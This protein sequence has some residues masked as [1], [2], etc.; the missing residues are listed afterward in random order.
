MGIEKTTVE[1]FVALSQHHPV[2]DVR[3][4]SEYN[5]AHIPGAIN[6]PLFNDDERHIVGTIYKKESREAAIK[7][8][9]VYFGPKMHEMISFVEEIKRKNNSTDKTILV[10]CWRGGMRSG[11]VAWLLD[12]YGFKVYT[13]IG[14]YKSFR[15]WVLDLFKIDWG[16]NILGGYTGSGKTIILESLIEKGEAV[17]DLEGIAGH[18]GS[19]FGRIGLPPQDSVEMFENKLA[20]ELH[21]ISGLIPNKNIWLEDE[22]QR[23][24]SVSIPHDLWNTIRKKKVYFIDVPFQ[25]RLEYLVETYG[26]LDRVELC[27]A[28]KRIEKKLGGLETKTAIAFLQEDNIKE[29]FSILLKYYDK[30]YRKSLEK[31]ENLNELLKEI[32]SDTTDKGINAGLILKNTYE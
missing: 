2:I 22:S 32:K 12:L 10:H 30:L 28:I 31:R 27:E 26:I 21:K 24:G 11:G 3:S 4:E 16:F 9:L 7:K 18:K 8:G 13:L 25:K 14:G 15:N 17:I 29:C 6:L 23:I 5:H 19:A 1:K 20:L